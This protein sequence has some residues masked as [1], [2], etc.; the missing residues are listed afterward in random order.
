[1]FVLFDEKRISIIMIVELRL[2][3]LLVK[4]SS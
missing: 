1:V 2:N 3:Y 4:L